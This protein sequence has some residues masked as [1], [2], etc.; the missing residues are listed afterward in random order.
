MTALTTADGRRLAYRRFGNGPVLVG[1][2]GGPGFGS[3]SLRDLGGLDRE[4]DLVLLDPRGTGGSDPADDDDYSL[5]GYVAD[6]GELLGHLGDPPRVL[7]GHSHGGLV[8]AHHA[9]DGGSPYD[10]LILVDTPARIDHDLAE[11]MGTLGDEQE[12]AAGVDP[13]VARVVHWLGL[14]DADDLDVHGA[15]AMGQRDVSPQALRYFR[16][17][18]MESFDILPLCAAIEVPTLVVCG[19]QDIAAGPDSSEQLASALPQGQ[20]AV[21]D[22]AGHVPYVERPD[23][24]RAAVLRFLGS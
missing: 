12:P 10:A 15:A 11:R 9:A 17:H 3:G 16:D 22:D 23:R 24:F 1:H 13:H 4:L 7:L 8:A 21:I 6:V 2:P 5:D 19:A 20:L 18:A 14:I